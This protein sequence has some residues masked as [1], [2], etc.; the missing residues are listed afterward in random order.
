MPRFKIQS[1]RAARNYDG[2]LQRLVEII[3][4]ESTP[5]VCSLINI[6]CYSRHNFTF[7]ANTGLKTIG[8]LPIFVV[9][10]T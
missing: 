4:K 8:I 3:T 5:R 2:K 9:K 7:K 6:I 10:I 1:I